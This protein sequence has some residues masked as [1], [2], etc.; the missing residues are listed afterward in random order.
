MFFWILDVWA[1][2]PADFGPAEEMVY[3]RDDD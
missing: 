1:L 3:W 2:P